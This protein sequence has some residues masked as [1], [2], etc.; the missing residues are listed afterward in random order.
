MSFAEAQRHM[1]SFA[2]LSNAFKTVGWGEGPDDT[3]TVRNNPLLN[4]L[5]RFLVVV[6]WYLLILVV[7]SG[8]ARSQGTWWTSAFS[9]SMPEQIDTPKP[10]R[11]L[12]AEGRLWRLLGAS[13]LKAHFPAKWRSLMARVVAE[14]FWSGFGKGSLTS[15]GLTG[16]YKWSM[17]LIRL[18]WLGIFGFFFPLCFPLEQPRKS[19]CNLLEMYL[20]SQSHK[21]I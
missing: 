11:L 3:L 1:G 5:F 13:L 21:I 8:V 6:T 20:S 17:H 9:R 12:C 10:Q 15:S 4:L 7:R 14:V 16:V 18:N 2:K 19:S